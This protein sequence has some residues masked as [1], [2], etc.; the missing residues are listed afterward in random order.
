MKPWKKIGL[1]GKTIIGLGTLMLVALLVMGGTIYYQAIRV[2]IHE[3]LGSTEKNIDKDV[4]EIE[5]FVKSSTY[6]LL[7]LATTPPIQG[8]IRAKDNNGIDPLTNDKAEYW[9]SRLEQIFSS[10]LE[11]HP[12]YLQLSYRDEKGH[13]IVRTDLI[14]KTVKITPRKALQNKAPYPCFTETM[15]LRRSE[16]YYSEVNLNRENGVMQIPHTP[17]FR[18]AT[19]VYDAQKKLR[20]VV[21]INI[22]AEAMFRKIRTSIHA[23]KKYIVNQ[24][25]YFLVHPDRTKE[26]GFDLGFEYSTKNVMHKF[27]DDMKAQDSLVKYHKQEQHVDGF[28]KIFFDPMNKSR[29]WALIYEIPEAEALKTIYLARNTMLVVGIL[30]IV[31]SLAIITWLY[32]RQ[33]VSPILKLS[34][35]VN[36]IENGD[37]TARVQEDGRNDEMGWLATSI[38]RMAGIIEKN[39]NELTVLNRIT[40]A[41][42]SSL[43]VD[44]IAEKSLD[45][46]LDLQLLKFEK[47]AGIFIA[48]EKTRTLRLAA[49]RGF[50]EE[51]KAL[52]A[53]VPFGD[54]L[55]GIAA[56]TGEQ[57]ISERCCDNPQ[58]TRKYAGIT[59]HG[60]LIF[61]LK[62]DEKMIGVLVLYLAADTEISPE[63]MRLYHALSDILTVSL[64]NALSFEN[65]NKLKGRFGQILNSLGE[66][67]YGLDT[68]G[69][70]TFMNPVAERMLGYEEGELTG[71]PLHPITHHTRPDGSAYPREECRIYASFRDNAV[72]HV[73]DEVFWRKDGASFPVEYTSTP[74]RDENGNTTGAVVV[75]TDITERR[76][77]EERERNRGRILEMLTSGESLTSVLELIA[78]SIEVEDPGA[79]CSI[80]LLDEEGKHLLNGAAPSLPDFYNQAIHGLEIGDGIGSCGTAAVTKQRVIVADILTHPYWANFRDLAQKANLRSCWSEPI[81]TASDRVLGTF[82]VYHSEPREPD[83]E[84][85]ERIK[86]AADFA[87]LAIERKQTEDSLRRREERY[88]SLVTASA[89]IVWTTNAEGEVVDDLP[90]WRA[91]TGQS[92]Q[93][94][95]GWGWS[96]AL[97]P[98]DRERTAANWSHAVENRSLYDVECRIRHYDGEY[99]IFAARGVPVL[100]EDGSIR[101]WVGTCMDI[102]ERKEAEQAIHRSH[103]LLSAISQAQSRFISAA[104]PHDLFDDLLTNLLSITDSEYGFIGEIF[105]DTDNTP[106]LKMHAITNIAWDEETRKCYEEH[107]RKGF[108][109]RNLKSLYGTVITTGKLLISNSPS[110]DPRRGGIPQ[111]HP[112]INAL[113]CMPFFSGEEIVGMAGIANRPGGYDEELAEYLQPLIAT[114]GNIIEAHRNA[115]LRKQAE[116]KINE[117]AET[118]EIKVEERTSEL[119]EASFELKKLFNAIEQSDE[120]IVITDINGTIQYVNPAFSRR[121]GYSREEAIGKNPRILQ[122]GLTPMEVYDDLWKTISSGR[123]WKGTLINKK[124]S[125]E[126]YYEDATIAPVFDKQGDITHF[127]ASKAD[128]TDRIMAEKELKNKN[129]E[130]EMAK[131]IAESANRAKSDFLANMS[132]ELRTP[133]NAII[134]FSEV[135]IDGLTGDLTDDQKG[136]L[137]DISDSGN[138]LLSLINDILDLSKVEAGKMEFEPEEFNLRELI[139]GSLAMVKEKAMKHGIKLKAE[140]EEEIGDIEADERKI[141]QVIF[142]LLSNAMKFT[143]DGGSVCVAARRVKS[144]ELGVR[145]ESLREVRSQES[146]V[147]SEEN[148]DSEHRTKNSEPGDFDYI[149]ITVEDTGSGISPEDQKRLFQPFQQL[150]TS[151]TKKYEG[152]G[153]GLN[154]CKKFVELHGGTIWVESE[155][156]KG[157]RF[158]FVIP[159]RQTRDQR[160][161]TIDHRP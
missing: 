5:A 53:T 77:M 109:F 10:F 94:I 97:H 80:L 62:S 142:N 135:M 44:S 26:F 66:G 56:E 78:R 13:E 64:Q 7:I 136:Y 90:T 147:R 61:P 157:S 43:L 115:K 126:L 137:K 58:H 23:T 107:S 160:P 120:S 15:K 81:L 105:R 134:G 16:V 152:T 83:L 111:G 102:T 20:G 36:R 85:I 18:I 37:L 57:I 19:P 143:P 125:G 60:H 34:E 46:I 155:P 117:Y 75:F 99:R 92:I 146:G 89:Q 35:T 116:D 32:T 29:Y 131:E 93:E 70:C 88:H 154:L 25:G 104:N 40:M 141:K 12:E 82:A 98:E 119:E 110:T 138:H 114:C 65:I 28:K 67:I 121:T 21:V 161:E 73:D 112:P 113:L 124:K 151:Y 50:S 6:D 14:E 74:I 68:N 22:L 149:E 48:D 45:A 42:T 127:V 150:E 31:F 84:D 59:P 140:V 52:D 27:A 86:A 1:K 159:V 33:L 9:Y 123:S 51:Q 130:L 144:S 11:Y 158:V 122:S 87:R 103:S 100:E 145:S 91:Y 49:S 39:V 69:V 106:Y 76:R 148:I 63:E 38:N 153:L 132:H 71:S 139:E 17:V 24:D 47:K 128:V 72:Y 30:V 79:L 96:N 8:I 101:E 118:L 95:K 54:C 2:A 133:L 129:E 156:G 41:S 55:C 3:S 4:M 108:E